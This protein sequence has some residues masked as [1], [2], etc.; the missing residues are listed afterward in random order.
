MKIFLSYNSLDAA[1]ALKVA[2]YM[3]R[4]GVNYYLDTKGATEPG[5]SHSLAWDNVV[6]KI[7]V[8]R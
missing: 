6:D 5:I 2:A 3:E 7:K 8:L 1:F 4:R